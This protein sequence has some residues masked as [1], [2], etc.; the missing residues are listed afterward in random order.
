MPAAD[1]WNADAGSCR[2]TPYVRGIMADMRRRLHDLSVRCLAAVCA[3]VPFV[4]AS[5]SVNVSS[6]SSDAAVTQ[7]APSDDS[8][9]RESAPPVSDES[10]CDRA[11]RAVDA[12][13]LQE[14][15]GQ[16]VMAPL[17]AGS[18]PSALSDLIA[19]RHVGSILLIGNW[20]SGVA[21]VAQAV[22]ALQS[23]AADGDKLLVATDQEGGLV[24]HLQ[25]DGFDRMPSATDQGAMDLDQ[26]RDSASV[27]GSQLKSAGVNIDLAPVVGTV[28]VPRGSNAPIGALDRDFGLDA[29]GNAEHAKA[30]IQG[31]RDA[32]VGSVV[33]HYPGL[34][35]VTGNTDFTADGILDTTTTLD[36]DQIEAFNSSLDANPAMVMMSLATYQAIDPNNPAVFSSALITDYLRGEVGFQGV[37]TSDSMSA[38]ALDGF[39][40]DDLGVRLVDAGGDLACIGDLDYVG[41]ILDGLYAKASSDSAF[42]KKVRQSA[43]RVMTLKYDM[44]L[45][46]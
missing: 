29:D 18:D 4:L 1:G 24:Q 39:E 41:L 26:L 20:T 30:F 28:T 25:G 21:G 17:Y 37:V 7:S 42:S 43:I 11:V 40:P 16:L 33:K 45:A 31:M 10:S 38:A 6:G 36:C 3:L 23:Y 12:M 34:G 15:V 35:S 13:T 8:L 2:A 46:Q 5:C 9:N 14:R 22:S 32:G 19:D 44:G 27:W